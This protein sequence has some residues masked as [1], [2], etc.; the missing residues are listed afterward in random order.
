MNKL[1]KAAIA[2]AAGIALLLGGAGTFA[3]WNSQATIAGGQITAGNLTVAT[4]N[5]GVWKDQNGATINLATYR[6]VPGDTLTY[7][8]DI[9]INATGQNLTAALA[10]G[11]GSIAPATSGD[12][13]DVALASALSGSAVLSMNLVTGIT[14]SGSSYTIDAATLSSPALTTV[15]A[16]ITFPKDVAT[17]GANNAAKLGVVNLAG[18]NVTLTQQ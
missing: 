1:T 12:T 18:M 10:L 7:T 15:T 8:Q 14:G 4:T 3:V 5:A 11:A 13:E 17:V 16:T 2:G 9:T 6:I